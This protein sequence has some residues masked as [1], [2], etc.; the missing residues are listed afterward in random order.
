[1]TT[2]S[3][4]N[5]S[6]KGHVNVVNVSTGEIMLDQ[7][8][9]IHVQNMTRIIARRLSN[10]DNSSLFRL[11]FGNEGTF[12][13]TAGNREFKET[14]TGNTSGWEARLYREIYSE[15]IDEDSPIFRTDPGSS[16]P[17]NVRIGGGEYVDGV[18]GFGGDLSDGGVFSEELAKK[19]KVTITMY[20]NENEPIGRNPFVFDEIG[21]YSDG[22]GATAAPATAGVDVGTKTS[23]DDVAPA[24]S[25]LTDYAVRVDVGGVIRNEIIQTTSVG[26]GTG[27]AFTYGDVVQGINDG[28]WHSGGDSLR[29]FVTFSITDNTGGIYPSI[30]GKET[31]GLIIAQSLGTGDVDDISFPEDHPVLGNP[32]ILYLLAGSDWG[33]V[34][35]QNTSGAEAG[36]KNNSIDS[37]RERERLLSHL[38]FTPIEKPYG[39]MM[40]ITY[41]IS[42]GVA[43]QNT[44]NASDSPAIIF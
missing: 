7:Y 2:S 37:S 6:I 44:T 8:N 31:N 39:T 11:A 12:I 32:N 3:K 43:G 34:N 15:V 9:D 36:D 23:S 13:N 18:G 17:D 28:S 27:G 24:L 22:I 5:I 35:V 21:L 16:G 38:I 30:T 25:P 10:E 19:S 14:N 33:N 20:I 4:I 29:D 26:T 41:T 1:M 40:R 42:V